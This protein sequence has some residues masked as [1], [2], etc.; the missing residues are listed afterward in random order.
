VW[1]Q[2]TLAILEH[3]VASEWPRLSVRRD[4][5]TLELIS[6]NGRTL[7]LHPSPARLSAD[8]WSERN[9]AATPVRLWQLLLRPTPGV[10]KVTEELA[11]GLYATRLQGLAAA[12]VNV[13]GAAVAINP[14][15]RLVGTITSRR[16][17][18]DSGIAASHHHEEGRLIVE[19]MAACWLDERG[20][21]PPAAQL[22]AK[23]LAK[24]PGCA[25][26]PKQNPVSRHQEH[27]FRHRPRVPPAAG[28]LPP[29]SG[30][31]VATEGMDDARRWEIFQ[32]A[33]Q[34][35]RERGAGPPA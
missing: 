8:A 17:A 6:P 26:A 28:Q 19:P 33:M 2:E 14:Q 25:P 18:I 11:D 4:S 29:V 35:G 34:R 16:L 23:H 12:I 5:A 30:D 21:R 10:L 13:T 27:D 32:R 22:I 24:L 15:A 7:L 31:E 20:V 9:L 3:W 1:L